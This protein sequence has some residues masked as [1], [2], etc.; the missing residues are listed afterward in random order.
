MMAEKDIA[1]DF[2]KHFLPAEVS[3]LIDYDSLIMQKDSFLD[4]KIR[5]C[6]EIT[7]TFWLVLLPFICVVNSL[8][9]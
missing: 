8:N 1:I 6:K 4:D 5:N 2:L 9:S 7:Y 3:E